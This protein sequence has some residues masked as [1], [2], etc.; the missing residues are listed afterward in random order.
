[1]KLFTHNEEG[2]V[3]VLVAVGLTVLG[4]IAGFAIDIGYLRYARQQMQKAADAGAL[5]ASSTLLLNNNLNCNG[6]LD[7]AMA[8]VTANGFGASNV[9]VTWPSLDPNYGGPNYVQV[10]VSQPEPLFFMH[11]G[12]WTTVNVGASSIGS[13]VGNASGC[14]YALD[15]DAASVGFNVTGTVSVT[16]GIYVNSNATNSG[17]VNATEI[18]VVGDA[19]GF[20]PEPTTIPS[21]T[22]PLVG[23]AA[24]TIGGCIQPAGTQYITTSRTLTQGTYCGGILI[25][26]ASG[27]NI[28]VTFSPGIYALRG[29][30]TV[31]GPL[32]GKGE[33]TL[34]GSGITFYNCATVSSVCPSGPGSYQPITLSG[35]AGTGFP[36]ALSA[37]TSGSL[38]GILV[39]EDRSV[40][41][42]PTTLSTIDGS[43]GEVYT[44]AF[45]FPNTSINYIGSV[46][47]A[48]VE[49]PAFL[50]AQTIQMSGTVFF[51]SYVTNVGGSPL[52]SPTLVP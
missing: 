2:Q 36:G 5:A 33:S 16:C 27:T 45:Y 47:T 51:K 4:L 13:A 20:T 40:P 29:G 28:T 26:P 6:C 19:S 35:Y 43:N 50:I 22:D 30:L 12:G 44:G 24:P 7:A 34:I 48:A 31:E 42:S 9:T 15:A 32:Q 21:F 41:L 3:V 1:M 18:G 49:S 14:I 10:A 8:D 38:A 39:F 25:E 37:P 52:H 17:S 46:G 11:I 23:L